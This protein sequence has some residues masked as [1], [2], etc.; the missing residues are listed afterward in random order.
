MDSPS[1]RSSCVAEEQTDQPLEPPAPTQTALYRHFDAD[2]LLLYVGISL[3]PTYRLSQHGDASPWFQQIKTVDIEW[4]PSR[5]AALDAERLAIQREGPV[6]NKQ[7]AIP[8]SLFQ[9]FQRDECVELTRKVT[10]FGATYGPDE[11]AMA[12]GIRKSSLRWALWHG[13]LP[14]FVTGP[15]AI[16]IT[17]WAVIEYL[18]ALAAGT[19]RV[20]ET[21]HN[22]DG[23]AKRLPNYEELVSLKS[24]SA[25]R[26]V[27]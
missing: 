22:P 12:I 8:A 3:S 25:L 15:R 21:P 7:W 13:D 27:A 17:G 16:A 26:L 6:H 9:D 5:V 2:G 10:R 18:E 20:R 11:A 4:F 1:M 23:T 24:G 19:V 14:Y